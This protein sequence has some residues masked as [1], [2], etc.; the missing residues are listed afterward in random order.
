M[1]SFRFT[2]WGIVLLLSSSSRADST[3]VRNVQDYV[4]SILQASEAYRE[5]LAEDLLKTESDVFRLH[6]PP[7]EEMQR[8]RPKGVPKLKVIK[9][10]L[11][12][13]LTPWAIFGFFY[14]PMAF[15]PLWFGLPTLHAIDYFVPSE[16]PRDADHYYS[17]SHYLHLSSLADKKRKQ[18]LTSDTFPLFKTEILKLIQNKIEKFD[19]EVEKIHTVG[20]APDA[21]TQRDLV[22]WYLEIWTLSALYQIELREAAIPYDGNVKALTTFDEISFQVNT[23]RVA[24][25]RMAHPN[26][27]SASK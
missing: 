4:A 23:C 12:A 8:Y 7:L 3:S 5:N 16:R 17:T 25:M 20:R 15:F 26:Y 6:R 18:R 24:L 22:D 27:F 13:G 2:L 14:F 21:F 1:G 11:T 19:R 10:M 9:W